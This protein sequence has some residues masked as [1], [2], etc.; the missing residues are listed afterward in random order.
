MKNISATPNFRSHYRL[1]NRETEVLG[2]LVQGLTN[3]QIADCLRLRFYTVSTHVKNI[4][5]KL[6]V[7][8]R[9]SAAA[10]AASRGLV[11]TLHRSRQPV[12]MTVYPPSL[13]EWRPPSSLLL[14]D[15]DQ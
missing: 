2:L 13:N 11:K 8:K 7:R 12:K 1:S 4:Y 3:Q 10:L 5:K 15:V 6:G 9:S 14:T